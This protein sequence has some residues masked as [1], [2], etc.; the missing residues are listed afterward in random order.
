[1]TRLTVV[2]DPVGYLA[3]LIGER[4]DRGARH[5]AVSGGSAVRAYGAVA[6]RASGAQWWLVDERCVPADHPDSNT[7]AIREALGHQARIHEPR[8]DLEPEDAAWLY[9][10]ELVH[11]LG[12]EPVFDLVVLGLGEDGHTASLFPGHPE[13]GAAHAPVIGVRGSPKPPPERISLTLPVIDRA[14]CTVMLAAGEG[15]RDALARLRAGDAELP[16]ARLRGLDEI[17]CDAAAIS[18]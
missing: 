13:A 11:A 12:P 18:A 5:V 6:G 15:K 17:V 16:P 4:L 2:D 14:R 7:R 1:M 3:E 10:D 9:A 8:G